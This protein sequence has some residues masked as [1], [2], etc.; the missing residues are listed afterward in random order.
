M[1]MSWGR[2]VGGSCWKKPTAVVSPIS[3]SPLVRGSEPAIRLSIVLLPAPFGP[4]TP[5]RS[6]G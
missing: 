4:T 6:P 1:D 3:R 5:M 2:L